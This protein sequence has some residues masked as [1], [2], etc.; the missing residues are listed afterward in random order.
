[1]ILLAYRDDIRQTQVL[2]LSVCTPIRIELT[3]EINS[4]DNRSK[5][6]KL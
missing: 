2:L 6:I 1:M 5:K 3:L 4:N